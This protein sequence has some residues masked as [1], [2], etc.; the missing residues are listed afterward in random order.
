MVCC[1]KVLKVAVKVPEPPE[2]KP[3]EGYTAAGSLLEKMTEPLQSVGYML[4]SVASTVNVNSAEIPTVEGACTV[5]SDGSPGAG[6][7]VG[8][9]DGEGDGVGVGLGVGVG[10]GLGVGVGVGVP[11]TGTIA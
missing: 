3:P 6:V 2:I 7:L 10:I 1:P 5:N 9:G 11:A 4:N 8:E